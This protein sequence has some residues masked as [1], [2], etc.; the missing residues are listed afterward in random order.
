MAGGDVAVQEQS[1][2]VKLQAWRASLT[3]PPLFPLASN[4]PTQLHSE[5]V[6]YKP[7]IC[8]S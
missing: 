7:L 3:L 8:V 5:T 6:N 4:G 2:N 1:G